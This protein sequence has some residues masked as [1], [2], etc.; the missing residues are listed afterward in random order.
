MAAVA[1]LRGTGQWADGE[2]PKNFREY[3]LWRNSR[4]STPLFALMSKAKTETT[5]DQEFFWWD[6]PNDLVRLRVN[7]AGDYGTTDTTIVVD[8]PDPSSSSPNLNWGLATHL[9]PGDILM[10]EPATDAAAFTPEYLLVTSVQSATQFTCTRG[11]LGSTPAAIVDDGW[12]LLMGASF[13]QG[14]SAP[15]ASSRN[16]IRYDNYT[17]IFKHLYSVSGSAVATKTR[18]GDVLANERKRKFFD[19]SRAIEL[20]L[21]FGRKATWTGDNGQVQYSTDGLRRFIPTQNTTI[22]TG[23]VTF[24]GSN[25]FLDAVYKVF[26]WES[27]AGDTRI[28]LCGNVALNWMSKIAA[29]DTNTQIQYGGKV[30]VYGLDLRE[31]ILPQGR[32]L[33]RTHPLLNRHSLYTNSMW[34]IDFSALRWRPLKGRDMQKFDNVQTKKDDAVEGFWQTEGGLEVRYGGLTLGY[35]GGLQ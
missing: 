12:L 35:L 34:L 7:K 17:Q 4:G 3:I 26:D 24:S 28:A 25:N 15:R 2:R 32:L 6:E 19:H 10:V 5:D 29:R 18:T 22:F 11:A 30:D 20:S 33:L 21:M 9:V 16:P 31:F 13:A 14:T 23:A 1:G 8:S 27:D